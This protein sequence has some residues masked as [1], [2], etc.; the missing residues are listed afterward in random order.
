MEIGKNFQN[1]VARLVKWIY[2][3]L[4]VIDVIMKH[5]TRKF[6]FQE[7]TL[8]IPKDPS[9]KAEDLIHHVDR[10]DNKTLKSKKNMSVFM[11]TVEGEYLMGFIH[12]YNGAHTPVPLPDFTLVHFDF[13]HNSNAERKIK[14]KELFGK[15]IA[16]ELEVT[17]DV[18][19]EIYAYYGYASSC[20]ISLFTS[21]ESFV[22][23]IIPSDKPFMRELNNKTELY[24]KAQIQEVL[25]FWDKLKLVLPY[26][27]GK[28]FFLN[29]TPT[30]QH[31]A[32]LKNLR[33]D[34]IHTKSEIDYS[35]QQALLKSVLSF[36]Y[37]QTFE[38][39]AKFMNFYRPEYITECDCGA[40][41]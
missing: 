32:N 28:N 38:A 40:D 39:V 3:S 33:D 1:K 24:N 11:K 23:H 26:Y 22:N 20:I 15:L 12:N 16:P 10:R 27:Y 37:D 9:K 4:R 25:P 34:I 31:I 35:K 19:H 13:A 30:N 17:E 5:I 18:T 6:L 14:E 36:K 2:L 21:I 7:K 8:P 41:F 29:P